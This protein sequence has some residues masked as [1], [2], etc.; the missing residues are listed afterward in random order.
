MVS[1]NKHVILI[2]K[3]ISNKWRKWKKWKETLSTY[4]DEAFHI[5]QNI[6]STVSMIILLWDLYT[7]S[8]HAS[9]PK[10]PQWALSHSPLHLQIPVYFWHTGMNTYANN[11]LPHYLAKSLRAP[12]HNTT[13][14]IFY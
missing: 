7:P 5:L 13:I 11:L 3:L 12:G 8:T 2:I 1:A 4:S 14:Y 6:N 9:F 10:T